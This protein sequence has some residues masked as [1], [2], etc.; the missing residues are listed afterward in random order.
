MIHCNEGVYIGYLK[1]NRVRYGPGTLFLD[2]RKQQYSHLNMSDQK[3]DGSWNDVYFN[4]S[5]KYAGNHIQIDGYFKD[6][7]LN[8]KTQTTFESGTKFDG[9]L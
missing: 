6:G 1:N 8:G 3:Y 5:G 7:F 2:K 9:Y 4:G